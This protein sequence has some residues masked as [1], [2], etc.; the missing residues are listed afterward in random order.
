[1]HATGRT[2]SRFSIFPLASLLAM[3]AAMAQT[4]DEKTLPDVVVSASRSEQR[5]FDAPAAVSS[6]AVDPFTAASPLVNLSELTLTVPGIAVRDRQNYA[7]DLQIAVRGFGS[8]ST[9]GVRGV[10]LFVDGI[11]ATMPDGQGQA[12]TFDLANASRVEVLRGPFAQMYGNASGGVVQVFT[13]D[14][15]KDGFTGRAA[16]GFGSDGQWQAGV[17]LAG[18][19]DRLG[20]SLDAWTYQTD[21]YRDHSAARRYQLNAKIVAQPTTATKITGQF[22]YFTQPLAEDPLGLTRAQADANPRQ[23]VPAATQF[24]TGK[25][26]EQT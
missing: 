11:P 18:G 19:N 14:P 1:M 15:P 23:T 22:N 21:G 20:G 9:F 2:L 25:D 24:N 10:R 16:T 8:R 26:V 4:A 17:A 3:P 6:I 13:P 7:Q 12:S 5:Q